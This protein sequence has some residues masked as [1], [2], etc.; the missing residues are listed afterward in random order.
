VSIAN[1]RGVS[2]DIHEVNVRQMSPDEFGEMRAT[3]ISSFDDAHIGTLLDALKD[4]WAWDDRFSFVAIVRDRIIGQVLYTHA[5]LD[6]QALPARVPKAIGAD[7]RR[8]VPVPS[9][10]SFRSEVAGHPRLP[11]CILANRLRWTP[12]TPNCHR[13]SDRYRLPLCGEFLR[14]E[15]QPKRALS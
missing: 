2:V 8:S 1:V 12:L 14:P 9:I 6:E 4:S 13:L 5:I 7:P 11:R 15:T 3:S 10:V